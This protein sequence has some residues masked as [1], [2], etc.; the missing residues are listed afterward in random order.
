MNID[1]TLELPMVYKFGIEISTLIH[2]DK[3]T[4]DEG[5]LEYLIVDTKIWSDRKDKY[6]HP[7]DEL[8]KYVES[9]LNGYPK[10]IEDMENY[11]SREAKELALNHADFQGE[12][13]RDQR[14]G[15]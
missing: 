11:A 15:L 14:A 13:R 4:Q 8:R 10:F 7:S 2:I 12:V 9:K 1:Y 3:V 6:V 5:V